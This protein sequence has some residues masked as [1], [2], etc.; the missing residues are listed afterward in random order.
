MNSVHN[1]ANGRMRRERY[2]QTLVDL[3]IETAT[4]PS[5]H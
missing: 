4:Q 2:Y 1:E 5:T 3:I